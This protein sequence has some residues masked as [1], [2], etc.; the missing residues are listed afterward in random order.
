MAKF[1]PD[2]AERIGASVA[3]QSEVGRLETLP[4][5]RVEIDVDSYSQ[6]ITNGAFAFGRKIFDFQAGLIVPV[7]A[8]LDITID[9]SAGLTA[10]AGEIGLG[11]VVASGSVAVLSGTATFEDV[12]LAGTMANLADGVDGV[13]VHNIGGVRAPLNGQTTAKDLY[14]N[15][16]STWVSSSDTANI[17]GTVNLWYFDAT[18]VDQ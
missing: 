17:S 5:K 10:T 13:E 1:R 15:I 12:A 9:G 3:D 14:L 16:A 2:T 4:L 11:T 18:D 6:A 8:A 7:A